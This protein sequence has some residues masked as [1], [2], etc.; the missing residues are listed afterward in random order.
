MSEARRILDERLAKGEIS[1]EE[2]DRLC[3]R[4]SSAGNPDPVQPASRAVAPA[5]TD[6]AEAVREVV[7]ASKSL[8]TWLAQAAGVF[9]I[10]VVLVGVLNSGKTKGLTLGNIEA[11]GKAVKFKVSNQS[12]R[13]NDV[14]V[15][16]KQ[17]GHESCNHYFKVKA[18]YTH[19]ITMSCAQLHAGDFTLHYAWA[20]EDRKRLAIS[21]RID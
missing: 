13:T 5:A 10:I 9:V 6:N 3:G 7:R 4:L 14:V 8:F 20:S 16:I 19:T 15:W 17:D 12:K 1:E 11:A 21:T 2:H 18:G